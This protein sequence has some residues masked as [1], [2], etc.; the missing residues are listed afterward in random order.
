MENPVEKK[1]KL[2]TLSH[3]RMQASERDPVYCQ[4]LGLAV[5]QLRDGTS[6]EQLWSVV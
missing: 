1:Y 5:E 3:A 6:V 2:D 4:E